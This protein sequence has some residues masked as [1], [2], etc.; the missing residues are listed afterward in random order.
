MNLRVPHLDSS[1]PELDIGFSDIYELEKYG[2]IREEVLVI[3]AKLASV[4]LS[5]RDQECGDTQPLQ[6]SEEMEQCLPGVLDTR[7]GVYRGERV[8]HDDLD[9]LVLDLLPQVF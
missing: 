5:L 8:D 4:L 7:K 9:P 3:W 6:E 2:S 1:Y